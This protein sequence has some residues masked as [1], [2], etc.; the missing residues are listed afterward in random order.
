VRCGL[1]PGERGSR[2]CTLRCARQHVQREHASLHNHYGCCGPDRE[3]SGL[4][5]QEKIQST[6]TQKVEP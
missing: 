1:T 3:S 5:V 4:A 6:Y 2:I